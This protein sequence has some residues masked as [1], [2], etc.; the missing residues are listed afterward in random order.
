MYGLPQE[1]RIAKILLT[2]NITPHGY[3][4]YRHIPG[5]W[6]QK[7]IPVNLYLLVDDSGVKYVGK[8]HV[9][10]LI[11]CINKHY[12]VSVEYTGSLYYVVML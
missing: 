9:E 5:L 3:C 6:N 10:N 7:W 11:N 1:G 12:T 4:Q 8:Q 2:I